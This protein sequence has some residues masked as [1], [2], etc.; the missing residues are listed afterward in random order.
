MTSE[1]TWSREGSTGP[2]L[3]SPVPAHDAQPELQGGSPEEWHLRFRA[4]NGWENA[5]PIG[6]LR[7][8]RELCRRW[9]R[10][11]AHTKEQILDQLVLEQFLISTPPDVQVLVKESGVTSCQELEE[12]LLR[13]SRKKPSSCVSSTLAHATGQ[14]AGTERAGQPGQE[15]APTLEVRAAPTQPPAWGEKR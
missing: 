2:E 6:D 10:P 4:F 3:P 12:L 9:L 5:D 7:V 1:L 11:E 15:V 13:D 8:L 14:A